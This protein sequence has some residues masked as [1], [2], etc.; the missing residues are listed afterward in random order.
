M[1]TGQASAPGTQ[2]AGWIGDVYGIWD[3]PTLV[4]QQDARRNEW[5][6][7]A[8]KQAR[9]QR[10]A[11]AKENDESIWCSHGSD[12]SQRDVLG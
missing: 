2:Q 5:Q 8:L 1:L 10:E 12:M 7:G 3:G 11:L 9:L 6:F 4:T